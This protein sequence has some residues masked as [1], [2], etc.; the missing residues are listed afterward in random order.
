M[1]WEG[2]GEVA[3]HWEQGGIS[4]GFVKKVDVKGLWR[5]T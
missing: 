3:Y 1:V 2:T 5:G 4:V